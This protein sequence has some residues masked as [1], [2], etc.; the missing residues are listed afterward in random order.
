MKLENER[1]IVTFVEKGGEIQSF[2]DKE[3]GIQY[4]WQGNEEHWSGKN[5]SLFPM[6]GNT[7]TQDYEIDGKRY[8]MKN[9]GLIRY[10]DLHCIKNDGKQVVMELNSDDHTKKQYPFDFH[11]E[12]AYELKDNMLTITYHITNTGDSVMPFSFGLHPGFN[13]P[14]CEGESFE[15]YTMR[16]SNPEKMQQL[17]FDINKKEDYKLI[18]VELEEIPCNY[19]VFE[20]YATLIYKGAKSAY[21]TLEGK[22]GHGVKLSIAGYPYLALWTAKKGAPFVC[23]EP[24][25]GHADFSE[26]K[27]DFYHREGTMLLSPQKTFTTAYTIEVF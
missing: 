1:Y 21:L 9:H 16:F 26:V 25:Y 10:A 3:T 8:A 17:V 24:W 23:L 14:L 15:D 2:T 18:N 11:Y 5:P 19:D 12:I 7:Y 6:V 20:K 13:C 22:K 4:M 27:E